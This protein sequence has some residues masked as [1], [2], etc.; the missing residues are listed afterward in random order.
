VNPYV[1]RVV[2][3]LIIVFAVWFDQ[4]AKQRRR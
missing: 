3:G 2:I 4:F 1:Q